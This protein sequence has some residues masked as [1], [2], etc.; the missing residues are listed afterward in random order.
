[1]FEKSPTFCRPTV[2]L[3]F[4]GICVFEILAGYLSNYIMNDIMYR[5]VYHD[6]NKIKSIKFH[7]RYLHFLDRIISRGELN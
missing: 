1:M 2:T 4:S 7:S 6:N 5:Y 3:V